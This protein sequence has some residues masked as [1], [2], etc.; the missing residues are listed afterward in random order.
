MLRV[1]STGKKALQDHAFATPSKLVEIV[2]AVN[3]A[4]E[5]YGQAQG[6]NPYSLLGRGY[7]PQAHIRIA[8]HTSQNDDKVKGFSFPSFR[9]FDIINR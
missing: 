9:F 1:A 5:V 6:P 3:E 2:K 8:S 7:S 4:L